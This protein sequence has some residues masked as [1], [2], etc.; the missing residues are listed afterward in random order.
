MIGVFQKLKELVKTLIKDTTTSRS[1]ST[2]L[3]LNQLLLLL[4]VTVPPIT[5]YPDDAD[6]P[7]DVTTA[8]AGDKIAELYLQT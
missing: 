1:I 4:S 5:C 7:L 8:K 3:T 2:E 6:N